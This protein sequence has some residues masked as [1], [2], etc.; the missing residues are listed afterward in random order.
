MRKVKFDAN[1]LYEFATEVIH[2]SDLLIQEAKFAELT[3]AERKV[4]DAISFCRNEIASS[5][6]G[7]TFTK[8]AA[9]NALDLGLKITHQSFEHGEYIEKI[10]YQIYDEKGA[11]LRGFWK[12]RNQEPWLD[13]WSIYKQNTNK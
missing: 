12:E 10:R 11:L 2:I 4:I 6:F 13:G 9:F 1:S 3:E 5:F 7:E 8:A